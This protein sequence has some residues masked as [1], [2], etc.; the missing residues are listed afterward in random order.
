MAAR[1]CAQSI[2]VDPAGPCLCIP[3][4]ASVHIGSYLSPY[5]P[6]SASTSAHDC[7]HIGP[8]LSPHRLMSRPSWSLHTRAMHACVH[9]HGGMRACLSV[10][11]PV[12]MSACMC[13]CACVHMAYG[14]RSK[15]AYTPTHTNAPQS[16]ASVHIG[17][18]L[19]PHRPMTRSTP[20]GE[21][22]SM[23]RVG[24]MLMF[25]CLPAKSTRPSSAS[26][27]MQPTAHTSAAHLPGRMVGPAGR[28][29]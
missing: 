20:A 28:P 13:L 10:C 1:P 6:I 17:S 8:C 24:G 19:G 18:K 2:E 29:V 16:S 7:L 21:C 23:Y 4:G 11:M 14:C 5:R 12:F 3:C 27:I 26:P 25:V 22:S 15:R 9:A